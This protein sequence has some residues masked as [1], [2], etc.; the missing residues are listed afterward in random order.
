MKTQG[1][2]EI[3]SPERN[4]QNMHTTMFGASFSISLN[5]KILETMRLYSFE[6]K[7]NKKSIKSTE[8]PTWTSCCLTFKITSFSLFTSRSRPSGKMNPTC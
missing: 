3:V 6:N 5:E 7:E 2:T 1:T 4:R 8:M